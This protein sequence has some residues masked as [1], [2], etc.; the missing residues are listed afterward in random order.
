MASGWDNSETAL[1]AGKNAGGGC[2]LLVTG[3]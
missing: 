3:L 2:H 1:G